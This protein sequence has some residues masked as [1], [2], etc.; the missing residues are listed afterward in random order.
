MITLFD[1]SILNWFLTG[2]AD[3]ILYGVR[4]EP[5]RLDPNATLLCIPDNL[6]DLEPANANN[7]VQALWEDVSG[8]IQQMTLA[9][10]LHSHHVD[11]DTVLNVLTTCFLETE[12]GRG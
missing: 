9:S 8:P 10:I 3:G 11:T 12:V 5:E 2:L 4:L 1:E 7:V 6:I